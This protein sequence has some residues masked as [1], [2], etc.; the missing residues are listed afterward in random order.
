M[1]HLW[2]K[3]VRARNIRTRV[4]TR[5]VALAI[6]PLLL[7]LTV[8]WIVNAVANSVSVEG[9][10]RL[11]SKDLNHT[12]LDLLGVCK[13]YHEDIAESLEGARSVLDHTGAVHFSS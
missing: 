12:V 4:L 1:R 8:V 13:L 7:F 2:N 11:A 9:C 3:F 6:I 10:Y 5:G